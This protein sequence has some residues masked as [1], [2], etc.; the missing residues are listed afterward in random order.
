MKTIP[1]GIEYGNQILEIFNDAILNTTA[2]YEYQPRTIEKIENWFETKKTNNFPVIGLVNED[3]QLLGFGSYGTFRA[4]PAFKY[5]VEHS[6]YIHKN[7]RG[8]G[9][10]KILMTE[11]IN[12]A[13]KQDYHCLIAGIDSSN[14]SSIELHKKFNFEFCG[15][16]KQ[17][18]YKFNKWLDLEFYQLLLETPTNP[19]D[20]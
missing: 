14:E 8:L 12:H 16:V 15:R 20:G 11:I 10:G 13:K 19:I 17:A 1:I 7:H 18:G 5:S 9:L 6:L 4:F 3:N 2:L